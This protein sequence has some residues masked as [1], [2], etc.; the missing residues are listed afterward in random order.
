MECTNTGE[1]LLRNTCLSCRSENKAQHPQP[2]TAFTPKALRLIFSF[3]SWPRIR[4]CKTAKSTIVDFVS[5][6]WDGFR[7]GQCVYNS[8]SPWNDFFTG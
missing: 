5:V 8:K 3:R 7:E 4:A 1:Q 6:A 2:Q